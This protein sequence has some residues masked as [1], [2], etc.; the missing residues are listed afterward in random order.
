M[1]EVQT[2]ENSFLSRI[3]RI[4]D[5]RKINPFLASVG[6]VGGSITK[7][8]HKGSIPHASA[9]QRISDIECVNLNWLVS[10]EGEPYKT[11]KYAGGAEYLREIEALSKDASWQIYLIK[12][13]TITTLVFTRSQTIEVKDVLRDYY[14]V[15]ILVGPYSEQLKQLLNTLDQQKRLQHMRLDEAQIADITSGEI[16]SYQMARL[17]N[18]CFS[19]PNLE[20]EKLIGGEINTELMRKI[21]EYSEQVL[22]EQNISLDADKKAKLITAAYNQALRQ[23]TWRDFQEGSMAALLEVLK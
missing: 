5:D 19:C 1:S 9:L 16:G 21:I 4:M 23:K 2:K 12:L 13:D 22:V 8:Q 17:A 7:V 10:G 6:V 15:K 20:P 11:E 14:Q 3:E 18:K